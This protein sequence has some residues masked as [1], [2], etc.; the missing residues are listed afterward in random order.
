MHVKVSRSLICFSSF[1]SP[2]LPSKMIKTVKTKH[3]IYRCPFV[4]SPRYPL[5][6]PAETCIFLYLT[7]KSAQN[8]VSTA[9]PSQRRLQHTVSKTKETPKRDS[10][11][12][13][14]R[15]ADGMQNRPRSFHENTTT[16]ARGAP[17]GVSSDTPHASF[18]IYRPEQSVAPASRLSQTREIL[19]SLASKTSRAFT[20][21]RAGKKSACDD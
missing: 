19:L 9:V 11:K 3:S 21:N 14:S 10:T 16:V 12:N 1:L 5:V 8:V 13:A 15:G 6:S 2:L 20:C 17:R 18:S 7:S 4:V